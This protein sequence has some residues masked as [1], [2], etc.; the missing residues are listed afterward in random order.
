LTYYRPDTDAYFDLPWYDDGN[1]IQDGIK[2]ESK[3]GS[4]TTSIFAGSYSSLTTSSGAFIN[5]P[6]VGRANA[7]R[8][9]PGKP[10]DYPVPDSIAA[11]QSA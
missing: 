2:L 1:Y 9:T 5:K 8:P 3:F 6:F 7:V 4:A 10:F 11:N